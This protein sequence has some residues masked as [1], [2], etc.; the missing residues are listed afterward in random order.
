MTTPRSKVPALR[1]SG[2]AVQLAIHDQDGMAVALAALKRG[3]LASLPP[4]GSW[5]DAPRPPRATAGRGNGIP[6]EGA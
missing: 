2:E 3:A 1:S 6:M 4:Q 5:A